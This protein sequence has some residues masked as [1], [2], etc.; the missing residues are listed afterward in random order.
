MSD[1]ER[2]S[3]FLYNISK[4]RPVLN[5]KGGQMNKRPSWKTRAE[6]IQAT[7]VV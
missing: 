3:L 4:V 2:K 7:V 6:V 1:V 5:L